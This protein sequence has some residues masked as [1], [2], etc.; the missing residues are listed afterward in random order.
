MEFCRYGSKT[1][2]NINKWMDGFLQKLRALFGARLKFVGRQGSCARQEA[3][4]HSGIEV[5]VILPRTSQ[6]IAECS[7]SWNTA[8]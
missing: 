4:A 8:S 3:T 6:D 5:V 7:M 2:V 1:M